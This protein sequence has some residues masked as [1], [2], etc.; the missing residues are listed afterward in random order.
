MGRALIDGMI[1]RL[2]VHEVAFVETSETTAQALLARHPG[3]RRLAVADAPA[4]HDLAGAVSPETLVLIAVKPQGFTALTE[5][6]R[7]LDLAPAAAVSVMAGVPSTRLAEAFR[8]GTP[9]ARAM[10]NTPAL[11]GVG[12]TGLWCEERIAPALKAR[13]RSVFEAVGRVLD[14]ADEDQLHAVTA[15]SGS[16]PA[17]LFRFGEALI[18]AGV[19]LGIDE[20]DASLLVR[21]T[22]FGAATLARDDTDLAALREQVTSPGGTTAAALARLDADDRLDRL[23]REALSAAAQRSREFAAPPCNGAR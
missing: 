2:G 14:V 17:Y 23:I 22:L 1:E 13:I 7:P 5:Q 9:L 11:A 15:L 20:A 21:E 12:M 3:L 16:G 18:A 19:A 4:H 10:P 8:A 6:L